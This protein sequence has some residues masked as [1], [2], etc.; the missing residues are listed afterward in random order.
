MGILNLAKGLFLKLFPSFGPKGV[1]DT[2]IQVYKRFKRENPNEAENDILNALITSRIHAP[3]GPSSK[4]R[5][6]SHY[7]PLLEKNNKTLEEV[8][9][10]I[11]EYEYMSSRK[12]ELFSGLAKE[13]VQPPEFLEWLQEMQ[14]YIQKCVNELKVNV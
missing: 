5:E 11:F 7:Q 9:W 13:G 2:Q 8:L 3:F 14:G 1:I 4:E 10:S 6:I 12:E